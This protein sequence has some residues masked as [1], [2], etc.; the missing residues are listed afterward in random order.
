MVSS[1]AIV[2]ALGADSRSTIFYNA[3]KGQMEDEILRLN[4]EKTVIVRPSLLLGDRNETRIGESIA[5]VVNKLIGWLMIGPLKKYK[6]IPATNVAKTML[7][8]IKGK[9]TGVIIIENDSMFD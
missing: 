3:V 6:G 1:I 2:S 9:T 8:Q 7:H 5:Q 4:F